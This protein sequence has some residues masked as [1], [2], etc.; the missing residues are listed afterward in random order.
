MVCLRIIRKRDNES[1]LLK[2]VEEDWKNSKLEK[3]IKSDET[4]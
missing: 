1:L 3:I 2:C 4:K